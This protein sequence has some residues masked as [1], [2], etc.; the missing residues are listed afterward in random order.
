[1]RVSKRSPGEAAGGSPAKRA[2]PAAKVPTGQVLGAWRADWRAGPGDE[3]M[4]VD[5]GPPRAVARAALQRQQAREAAIA[6]RFLTEVI[7]AEGDAATVFADLDTNQDGALTLTELTAGLA[8]LGVTEAQEEARAI[9]S[10]YD[11]DRNDKIDLHEFQRMLLDFNAKIQTRLGHKIKALPAARRAAGAIP[12]EHRIGRKPL[13]QPAARALYSHL[14]EIWA[15]P[16]LD[17]AALAAWVRALQPGAAAGAAAA[18]YFAAAAQGDATA[19]AAALAADLNVHAQAVLFRKLGTGAVRDRQR[20]ATIGV[21]LVAGV[22]EFALRSGSRRTVFEHFDA[23]G[24]QRLSEA[25]F[26]RMLGALLGGAPTA[27]DLEAVGRAFDGDHDGHLGVVEFFGMVRFVNKSLQTR[28]GAIA[29]ACAHGAPAPPPSPFSH[30]RPSVALQL[31]MLVVLKTLWKELSVESETHPVATLFN[32]FDANMDGR[33]TPGEVHSALSRAAPG[34]SVTAAEIAALCSYYDANRDGTIEGGEFWRMVLDFNDLF[35]VELETVLG[36]PGAEAAAAALKKAVVLNYGDAPLPA[37]FDGL[38]AAGRGALS[39]REL[40]AGLHASFAA[41]PPPLVGRDSHR[42]AALTA[43]DVELAVREELLPDFGAGP[44]DFAGFA[45]VVA[46]W[47]ERAVGV[48]RSKVAAAGP[49]ATAAADRQARMRAVFPAVLALFEA[50]LSPAAPRLDEVF[51]RGGNPV[52]IPLDIFVGCCRS[53]I[54]VALSFNEAAYLADTAGI[55]HLSDLSAGLAEV[56]AWV[57]ERFAWNFASSEQQRRAV[58]L[59]VAHWTRGFGP[60]DRSAPAMVSRLSARGGS[61]GLLDAEGVA[62]AL[63]R[64]GLRFVPPAQLQDLFTR[65]RGGFRSSKQPARASDFRDLLLGLLS[66][67]L[68]MEAQ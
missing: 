55:V 54:G 40:A 26:A 59:E 66:E 60:S 6:A 62:Q 43:R 23:D 21:S 61:G 51:A 14:R 48:F 12:D 68:A 22:L 35:Q 9:G 36:A 33:L 52:A 47:H 57:E 53:C 65:G 16:W 17:D 67:A 42:L 30:S 31:T 18:P 15:T 11:I 28:F 10:C 25:E 24:D 50:F 19:A 29:A 45:R 3:E 1:M 2:R 39:L 49:P 44:V 20:E 27:R 46:G 64:L 56:M 37:M 58:L 8:R 63:R 13:S 34:C 41:G 32:L 4:A 5:G 7:A 38:G